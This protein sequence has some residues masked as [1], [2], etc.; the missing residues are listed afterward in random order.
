MD[1]RKFLV[2]AGL[3]GSL[4]SLGGMSACTGSSKLYGDQNFY[5][6]KGIY[7]IPKLKLSKDRIIKETVGLRPFRPSGPRVEKEM[8]DKK[9]I[10]HNYGHGG[11]GWSLSWGTGHLA[12]NLVMEGADR[13]IALLGCGTVGIATATLLQESGCQVTI[14][15]KDVP[16]KCHFQSGYWYVVASLTGM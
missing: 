10:V 13:D 7:R 16:P 12:R 2:N 8:L 14:Y 15:T 9:T 3:A 1:R 6:N 5:I 11:S 4:V